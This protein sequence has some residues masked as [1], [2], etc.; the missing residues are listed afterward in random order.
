MATVWVDD[1]G[2]DSRHQDP[3]DHPPRPRNHR[4]CPWPGCGVIDA[5][6]PL[7]DHLAATGHGTG[8]TVLWRRK[9]GPWEK[10][11][12]LTY[13]GAALLGHDTDHESL[14]YDGWHGRLFPVGH[15]PNQ[16]ESTP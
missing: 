15:D 5:P 6:D 13:G 14:M 11:R 2:N 12:T 16:E 8:L 7:G 10:V 4:R 1:D 9:Y 3:A